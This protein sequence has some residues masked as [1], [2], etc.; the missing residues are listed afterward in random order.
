[1]LN[2]DTILKEED[3][4]ELRR[5]ESRKSLIS[6]ILPQSSDQKLSENGN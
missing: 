1:M 5:T 6:L 3:E 2:I 4:A